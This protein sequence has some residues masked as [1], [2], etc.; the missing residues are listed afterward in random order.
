M[1]SRLTDARRWI[2]GHILALINALVAITSLVLCLYFGLRSLPP[3]PARIVVRQTRESSPTDALRNLPVKISWDASYFSPFQ[4][5]GVEIDDL[6]IASFEIENVGG[7][8]FDFSE[9]ELKDLRFEH[10]G[11]G[12][13][14]EVVRG[15]SAP[16]RIDV[17]PGWKSFT[18]TAAYLNPE[19][20]ITFEV[21]YSGEKDSIAVAGYAKGQGTITI[22]KSQRPWERVLRSIKLRDASRE[23]L[24][25]AIILLILWMLVGNAV[26]E[27]DLVRRIAIGVVAIVLGCTAGY[28]F[29]VLPLLVVGSQLQWYLINQSSLAIVASMAALVVVGPFQQS[30]L[31]APAQRHNP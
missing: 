11:T 3:D 13:I 6:R 25:D 31:K 18:V 1:T 8:P 12:H 2:L 16:S 9:S 23:F 24:A 28:L 7:E 15:P 21:F 27:V 14:L 20:K 30:A 4:F 17:E 22:E 19:D 29:A 10:K 5:R 26:L